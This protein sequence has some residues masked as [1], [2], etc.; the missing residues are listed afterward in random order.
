MAASVLIKKVQR[1]GESRR[2]K[3]SEAPSPSQEGEEIV[4]SA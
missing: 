1:L 4:W 2:S 3:R